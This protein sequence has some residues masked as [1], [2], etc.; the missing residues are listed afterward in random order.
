MEWPTINLPLPILI[1]AVGL[2]LLGLYDA[3]RSHKS[4]S[5]TPTQGIVTAGLGLGYLFTAYMPIA[6]NQWLHASVP[7]R[8][9]LAVV[10]GLRA[11]LASPGEGTGK[12]WGIMLYDG[13]GG[14]LAGYS[15]GRWDGRI[16]GY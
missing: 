4:S 11:I 14:L 3:F 13:V 5:S 8:I 6:E 15:L 7:V 16:A 9:I 2:T 1:H 10:S 12:M